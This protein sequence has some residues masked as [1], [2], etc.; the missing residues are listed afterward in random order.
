MGWKLGPF[1]ISLCSVLPGQVL[2]GLC[3]EAAEPG[4]AP[5]LFLAP[6][7]TLC[8]QKG[9][10]ACLLHLALS[11]QLWLACCS[12]FWPAATDVKGGCIH[13]TELGLRHLYRDA[14]VSLW[15]LGHGG[16]GPGWVPWGA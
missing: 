9:C 2:I 13:A 11:V 8:K 10:R 6:P 7:T 3:P 15:C 5:S 12:P 14:A 16:A 4:S 1:L